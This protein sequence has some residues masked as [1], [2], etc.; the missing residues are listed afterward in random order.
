M[1]PPLPTQVDSTINEWA[2][3]K[4]KG[5][6]RIGRVGYLI[7]VLPRYTFST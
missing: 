7:T 2:V 6:V 3:E 4:V 5:Q 1:A